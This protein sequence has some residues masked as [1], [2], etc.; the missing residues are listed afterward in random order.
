MSQPYVGWHEL[1]VCYEA[2][3][4]TLDDRYN[5]EVS[6]GKPVAVGE[7]SQPSG[8]YG[9]LIFTAIDTDGSVP[10]P[11]SYTLFGRLLAPFGPLVTDD[12]AETSGSAQTIMLQMWTVSGEKLEPAEVRE[13]AESLTEI[14]ESARQQIVAQQGQLAANPEQPLAAES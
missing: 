10:T 6:S 4:W 5:L 12:F 13:L 14:R 1:C 7:F 9:Y 2:K 3:D 8:G 11:P